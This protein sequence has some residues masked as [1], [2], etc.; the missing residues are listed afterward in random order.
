MGRRSG[1]KQLP[2]TRPKGPRARKRVVKNAKRKRPPARPGEEERI[3]IRRLAVMRGR[4]G[5]Q[6][7]REIATSLGVSVSTVHEDATAEILAARSATRSEMHDWRDLELL[8]IDRAVRALQP[9]LEGRNHARRVR[10]AGLGALQRP[11]VTAA[12]ALPG[13]GGR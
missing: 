4:T 13:R 11:A 1:G 3:A 8:R 9:V 12:R 7:M 6:S 10:A 5:G 2:A